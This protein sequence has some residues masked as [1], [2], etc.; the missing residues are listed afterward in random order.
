MLGYSSTEL[1]QYYYYNHIHHEEKE[2]VK[3]FFT[4][5][6]SSASTDMRI[7]TR[8]LRKDGTSFW[9]SFSCSPLKNKTDE[10][11][12]VIAIIIDINDYKMAQEQLA[13]AEEKYRTLYENAPIGIFQTSLDNRFI[14]ANPQCATIL[15]YESPD[16]MIYKVGDLTRQIYNDHLN[17]IKFKK[18]F[19]EK[20]GVTDFEYI[21]TKKDGS[22]IWLSLSAKIDTDKEGNN[23]IDGYTYDI[24]KRK[25]IEN[26]LQKL[27]QAIENSPFSFIITNTFGKIEYVNPQLENTILMRKEDLI[28]KNIASI[29]ATST[30]ETIKMFDTLMTVNEWKEERLFKHSGKENWV[31]TYIYPL[32]NDTGIITNFIIFQEDITE[33]KIAEEDLRNSKE[34]ISIVSDGVPAH[35]AFIDANEKFLYVN[36][37]YAGLYGFNKSEIIGKKVVDVIGKKYYHTTL[38]HIRKVLKGEKVS[39]EIDFSESKN[40]RNLS[41]EMVP[42]FNNKKNIKAF[43]VLI[44]DITER[45][46]DEQEL[47]NAKE[48][49][50][51]ANRAKSEFLANMSH[52]IRTPMNAV[53]G[54]TDILVSLITDKIQKKYLESIKTSG[55]NLLT[56][57]NDIL[58]LS[59]IEAGKMEL[60]Y[61]VVD[62]HTLFHEIEQFFTVRIAEK[63]LNFITNIAKDIPKGL[64]LDETRLRQILINL[65]GNAVKFTEKGY[66]KLSV[67]I[68]PKKVETETKKANQ[69]DLVIRIEDT[70]I[71]IPPKSLN[72]IF[73]A[74]KQHDNR[75]TKKYEGT[76]LGLTITK[77]LIDIMHGTINV[78]SKVNTGSIFEIFLKDIHLSDI[79]LPKKTNISIGTDYK[80]LIFDKATILIADDIESNRNLLKE[81]FLNT[82]FTVIQAKNGKKAVEYAIKHIPNLIFM[83][84]R[85]P[86]MDGYDALKLI[87]Q[88][89]QNEINKIPIIA[90]TAS[91]MREDKEKIYNSGFDGYLQKPIQKNELFC[92]L[93]QFLKPIK[94]KEEKDNSNTI[95]ETK[96]NDL[97]AKNAIKLDSSC[98]IKLETEI[99]KLWE[100]ASQNNRMYDIK[101][102]G[103]ETEI[104]ATKYKLKK[105]EQ[106]S[107]DLIFAVQSFD[108][109]K[110]TLLLNN[111]PNIVHDLKHLLTKNHVNPKIKQIMV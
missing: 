111:Y 26:E 81:Y 49:A 18:L 60:R 101:K 58:D 88:N 67:N 47:K 40:N 94:N 109:E 30:K 37:S 46:K 57:I 75:S 96:K 63:K 24:T 15:G 90:L 73:E 106:F 97:L 14:N 39:F 69:I 100:L 9:S 16:E 108:I 64:L 29:W 27:S 1:I 7:E 72:T 59:K 2:K 83:D 98:I 13:K 5:F 22:K 82:N 68:V 105:L 48:Q 104:I 56:L 76:G 91:A 21:Y 84:I 36:K 4:E 12:A 25:K 28:G 65:I 42:H 95:S 31:Y 6:V 51:E 110:T 80:N 71:G 70:G 102:L 11:E 43:F 62:F 50:E 92:E 20:G 77:R 17:A 55:E 32:K 23:I 35:I 38:K 45:K 86:V 66:V 53:I 79:V 52:E 3:S 107:K 41:V 33:R 103:E 89:K 44:N 78:S 19:K 34:L 99:M 74:F 85:M 8:F 93:V 10:L 54:F 61:E 87:K